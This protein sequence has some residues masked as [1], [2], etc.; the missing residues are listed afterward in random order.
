MIR[1]RKRDIGCWREADSNTVD[2]TPIEFKN[3]E[4]LFNYIKREQP[5]TDND[6]YPL[7]VSDSCVVGWTVLGFLVDE[8][9]EIL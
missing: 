6:E 2:K 5:W 8:N 7:Q 9:N 3:E 1:F 4:E